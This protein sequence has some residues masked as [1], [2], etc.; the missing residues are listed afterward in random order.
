MA[1]NKK[2]KTAE[3]IKG[4]AFFAPAEKDPLRRGGSAIAAAIALPTLLGI[5]DTRTGFIGS[6]SWQSYKQHYGK[7]LE[8][9]VTAAET[10]PMMDNTSGS[11]ALQVRVNKLREQ[12]LSDVDNSGAGGSN[13]NPAIMAV[14]G[15]I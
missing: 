7:L 8:R 15:T 11:R 6:G 3:E 9:L 4:D 2:N 1:D 10:H 12:I 14:Q 13:K 5:V